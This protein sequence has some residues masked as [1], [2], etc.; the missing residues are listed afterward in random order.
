MVKASA[1]D[2]IIKTKLAPPKLPEHLLDRPRL[3]EKFQEQLSYTLSLIHAPAGYGKTILMKQWFDIA[4][5]NRMSVCWLSLDDD[6]N[7]LEIFSYYLA[8]T[9]QQ[10]GIAA[11]PLHILD[12]NTEEAGTI[13]LLAAG[14]IN[15]LAAHPGAVVIFLDD[16]HKIAN[17]N[18]GAL[19]RTLAQHAP[20]NLHIVIAS[21]KPADAS[22]T[23]FVS[24]ADLAELT[25]ADLK[26]TLEEFAALLTTEIN[27]D[28]LRYVWDRIE[29]WPIAARIVNHTIAKG[30]ISAE[31]ISNFSGRTSDLGDYISDEIFS[32]L[33]EREKTFLLSTCLSSRFNADL[34][35]Q[36]CGS[37][38]AYDVLKTLRKMDLFL[39][40][41]DSDDYWYRYHHLFQQFLNK[42]MQAEQAAA[43]PRLRTAAARWFLRNNYPQEAIEQ[44][45]LSNDFDLAGEIIDAVGLWRLTIQGK[46]SLATAYLNKLPMR[47]IEQ[48]PSLIV[49][50]IFMHTK[51][52]DIAY[53]KSQ[54]D[55]FLA[56][57]GGIMHW[58]G[59]PIDR[60]LRDSLSVIVSCLIDTYL[61][62]PITTEVLAST[63][64]LLAGT[65][66]DDAIF[67]YTLHECLGHHRTEMAE[68]ASALSHHGKSLE[69]AKK[70]D[71]AYAE[72]YIFFHR[73]GIYFHTLELDNAEQTLRT[74]AELI[75]RNYPNDPNLEYALAVYRAV[76]CY[77]KDDI[78]NAEVKLQHA[79]L[80]SHSGDSW[81][82]LYFALFQ[83]KCA[84][85]AFHDNRESLTAC[86]AQAGAI[87]QER[88]L[89]RLSQFA[90]LTEIKFTLLLE[91]PGSDKL[92]QFSAALDE[93]D[94][95]RETASLSSFIPS[96]L[97]LIRAR[98]LLCQQRFSDADALLTELLNRFGKTRQNQLLL[99]A[100]LLKALA[101]YNLNAPDDARK[102]C[103]SATTLGVT[104]QCK[105]FHRENA[106]ALQPVYQ[107]TLDNC[108]EPQAAFVKSVLNAADTQQRHGLTEREYLT[109]RELAKGLSN[110]EIAENICISEDTVKYRL[111]SVFKKWQVSSRDEAVQKAVRLRL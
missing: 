26:L 61:D 58:R 47:V 72:I 101:A 102:Y 46:I 22:E 104:T 79:C 89:T 59:N 11:P 40:A 56:A 82:T 80:E 81:I 38:D 91:N 90:R 4:A 16:Y 9:L 15:S 53:A 98:L 52:G 54:L 25:S 99:E 20:E 31:H 28:N 33:E 1:P 6:D 85:A 10:A 49:M 63:T 12:N 57:S 71:S 2:W 106:R 45:L 29:G 93:I 75:E 51:A 55:R 74:A 103:L 109:V 39:V 88:M 78:E 5:A 107:L 7:Q 100:M 43:I 95:Q 68:F 3:L 36:L 34:A 13:K 62:K 35:N 60:Q 37:G 86:I 65:N 92:K 69:A 18:I 27:P 64:Q 73:A 110:R 24:Q 96:L 50:H 23:R 94:A 70:L 97:W 32:S 17:R 21:R 76:A 44:A 108:P 30:L 19:V 105:I 87:A 77:L 8:A 14:F 111:K 48:Y 67:L 41:L 42:K 84:I 83:V 66:P